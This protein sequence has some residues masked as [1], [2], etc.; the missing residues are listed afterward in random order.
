L[1]L[2]LTLLKHDPKRGFVSR[3][4]TDGTRD[5]ICVKCFATV[6]RCLTD[7]ELQ[8]GEAMHVCYVTLTYWEVLPIEV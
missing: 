6:A 3:S 1:A 5:P 8:G 4:N 2:Q 7:S